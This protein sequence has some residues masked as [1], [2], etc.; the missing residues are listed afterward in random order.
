LITSEL[1]QKLAHLSEVY[2]RNGAIAEVIQ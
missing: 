2:N 1:E